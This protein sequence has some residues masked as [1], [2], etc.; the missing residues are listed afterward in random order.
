MLLVVPAVEFRLVLGVDVGPEH[1]Q[2]RPT[3]LGHQECSGLTAPTSADGVVQV[4][5]HFASVSGL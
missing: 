2:S 3:R 1:Q 4:A 5:G